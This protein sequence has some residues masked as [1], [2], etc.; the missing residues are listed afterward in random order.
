MLALS[1]RS[2][3]CVVCRSIFKALSSR[4]D[5]RGFQEVSA[6]SQGAAGNVPGCGASFRQRARVRVVASHGFKVSLSLALLGVLLAMS[7]PSANPVNHN[8]INAEWT[9]SIRMSPLAERSCGRRLPSNPLSS[10]GRSC[11]PVGQK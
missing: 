8:H 2:A 6:R 10:P 11:S 7:T 4:L 1:A 3:A 9:D 5:C